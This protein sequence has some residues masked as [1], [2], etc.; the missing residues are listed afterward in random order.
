VATQAMSNCKIVETLAI[1][2]VISDLLIVN[3]Y[4]PP[5]PPPRVFNFVFVWAFLVMI[6]KITRKNI[7]RGGGG[8]GVRNA[9]KF[10]Y[11]YL[12]LDG[13]T[14][15]FRRVSQKFRKCL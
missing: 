6:F 13:N 7:K 3:T 15:L 9:F 5:P 10:F 2:R 1:F 11:F 12:F 8:G 14:I 4:L